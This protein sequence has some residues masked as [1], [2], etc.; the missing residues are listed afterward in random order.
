MPSAAAA[1]RLAGEQSAYFRRNED[2]RLDDAAPPP[3]PT[4]RVAAPAGSGGGSRPGA[5]A[6]AHVERRLKGGGEK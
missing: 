1:F 2:D 6:K 4:A 5:C 3:L